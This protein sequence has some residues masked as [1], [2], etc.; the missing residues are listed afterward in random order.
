MKSSFRVKSQKTLELVPKIVAL[1]P[2]GYQLIE[3][4]E[5]TADWIPIIPEKLYI[6]ERNT[7]KMVD[8]E[9]LYENDIIEN[10]FGKLYYIFW[11]ETD[12]GFKG[13]DLNAWYHDKINISYALGF[14]EHK[15]CKWKIIGNILDG[16]YS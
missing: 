12:C 16:C 2:M 4:V 5:G 7:G 8:R 15:N 3:H 1:D 9:S 13:F 10:E 11:C 6:I 14:L